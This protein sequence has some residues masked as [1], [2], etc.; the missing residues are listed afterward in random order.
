MVAAYGVQLS[1]LRCRLLH[2]IAL[3]ACF[4]SVGFENSVSVRAGV[5]GVRQV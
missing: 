4:Q 1:H 2:G 3:E 5:D